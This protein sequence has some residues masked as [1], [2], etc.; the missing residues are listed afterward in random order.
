MFR[1]G[2]LVLR[3]GRKRLKVYAG[4]PAPSRFRPAIPAG[5]PNWLCFVPLASPMRRPPDVPSCPSLASFCTIAPRPT[6][7]GYRPTRCRREL[8][9]FDAPDKSLVQPNRPAISARKR[10]SK[11]NS[12]TFVV[13]V[14][15]RTNAH[16]RNDAEASPPQVARIRVSAWQAS[17]RLLLPLSN[18][19]SQIINPMLPLPVGRVA[20]IVPEFCVSET[21]PLRV[22]LC[23]QRNKK[24][25]AGGVFHLSNRCTNVVIRPMG[26]PKRDPSHCRLPTTDYR[27]L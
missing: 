2:P 11:P 5:R 24:F 26:D 16:L 9:L 6:A 7:P 3:P 21:L 1:A 12:A 14:L 22:T 10:G 13:G 20:R 19:K 8:A 17:P 25:F 4:P 23:V 15:F 18:H 27:L